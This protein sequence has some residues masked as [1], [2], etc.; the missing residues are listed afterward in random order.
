MDH[1]Q[2][3]ITRLIRDSASGDPQ[4]QERL[5]IAVYDDLKRIAAG[6]LKGERS[7]HT[8]HPTALVHEAYMRLANQH[9]TEWQDRLHFF[10][11]ASRIIRRILID[12]ARAKNAA[13][14]GGPMNQV[15]LM[16]CDAAT[17]EREVDL[18]S[19]DEALAELGE[20]SER[21]SQIVE[22]RYFGGLTMVEIA[23]VLGVG[24]RTVDRDWNIARAWLFHRLSDSDSTP[25]WDQA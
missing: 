1:A 15:S 3:D 7:D 13:K 22:L 14:R 20:I 19:L 17:P 21:Q 2:G 9:S 24:K 6:Q 10:A 11:I 5:V 23:T 4:Q 16:A 18:L 12:H 8:L 25:Q